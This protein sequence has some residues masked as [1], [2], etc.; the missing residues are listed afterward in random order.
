MKNTLT[1]SLSLLMIATLGACG[2][3]ETVQG[4]NGASADP[5]AEELA[6]APVA[7]LP[8]SVKPGKTGYRCKDSGLVKVEFLTDDITANITPEGKSPV[9]LIAAEKGKPFEGEGYKVEG[10][11]SPITITFPGKSAESCKA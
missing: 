4:G 2:Q 5:M 6:N 3:S 7:A 1:L 9:H 10:T 8:P 11:A